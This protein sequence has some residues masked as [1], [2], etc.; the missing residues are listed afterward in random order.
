MSRLIRW[1]A[2]LLGGL[3]LVAALGWWA[4]GPAWRTFLKDPPSDTDVLFW[5]QDQRDTGFGLSDQIPMVKTL[6]IGAGGAAKPLPMGAPLPLEIDVDAYMASQNSAALLILHKGQIRLERY[7]LHQSQDKRWTS[8]S[9]AKSMT[10]TLVGAAIADGYINS[11]DDKVSDYVDGLKGSAYD[12]VTLHQLLTMTSG[13]AWREDYADPT[14]DVALFRNEDPSDSVS[15]VVSYL[16]RLPRAHPPGAKFNYSTGETNLVGILVE[17]ATGKVLS[18]YLSEKIWRPYGMQAK[19]SWVITKT[20]EPISGCCVQAVARDYAR[21][22]QFILEG[23]VAD[24]RAVVPEG[25]LDAATGAQVTLENDRRDYGYQW[26]I[27]DDGAFTAI[28]IFGQGIFIDPKR[29][30]VIVTHSSWV[31][32]RGKAK[33]QE[34]ARYE[35]YDVVRAAIDSEL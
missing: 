30:L 29:D 22:G 8:F 34:A 20:G 7:G 3:V 31:D 28:G 4:I 5:T 25:W 10:S 19:G 17:A 21:F 24:E 33:G 15:A 35:F 27:L 14:S 2:I 13:V 11:L 26:W 12:D 16:R 6:E 23:G 9:V 32:A 1:L 18:D